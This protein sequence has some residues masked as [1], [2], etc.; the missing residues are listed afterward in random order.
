M[1][2]F[3]R[4]MVAICGGAQ[5]HPQIRPPGENNNKNGESNRRFKCHYYC[6]NFLTSQALRG[7]QNANKRE[8]Q[9]TKLAHLQ[10]TMVHSSLSNAHVYH[11]LMNY[12]L[13]SNPMPTMS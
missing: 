7:H 6:R 9:H 2:D 4:L 11:V 10:S 5:Q 1:V 13:G 3:L 8:R 12:Q